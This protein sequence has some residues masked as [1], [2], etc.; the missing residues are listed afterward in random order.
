MRFRA[1]FVCAAVTLSLVTT[2]GCT[3]T[4]KVRAI[5][6]ESVPHGLLT[7]TQPGSGGDTAS[8]TFNRQDPKVYFVKP[9]GNLGP[10]SSSVQTEDRNEAIKNVLTLLMGGPDEVTT[11]ENLRTTIPTGTQLVLERVDGGTAELS[12]T[13]PTPVGPKELPFFFG[14]IVLSVT[15]IEGVKSCVF[16]S[17]GERIT[18]SLPG[19]ETSDQPLTNGD[20]IELLQEELVSPTTSGTSEPA[21]DQPQG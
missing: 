21:L 16:S 9:S 13:S 1:L 2:A 17:N 20:Y 10:V 19:G 11:D 14:Q 18:A 3:Q 12:Y 7:S 5:P 8:P 4:N 15:S 6:D